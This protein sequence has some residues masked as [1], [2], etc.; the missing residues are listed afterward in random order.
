[1]KGLRRTCRCAELTKEN[2]GQTVTEV[3]G[4][5]RCLSGNSDDVSELC[6]DRHGSRR[7]TGRGRN[8]EVNQGLY[9][10]HELRG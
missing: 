5:N 8:K 7:L 6:H 4:E 1:M 10:Q 2:V 9:N 3:E